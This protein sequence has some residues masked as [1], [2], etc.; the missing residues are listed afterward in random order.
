M[1]RVE[2]LSYNF[3]DGTRGLKKINLEIERGEFLGIVGRNGSGKSTLVRHL[4]GLLNPTEGKVYVK[5][6]DT[7]DPSNLLKIRQT[8]GMVFQNPYT[9]FVGTTL[10]EDV[11]FGPENLA[12]P[13]EEIR[14]RVDRALEVV[15]LENYKNHS[16]KTLSGGQ[17]QCAAI[18][19]ALAMKSE[20]IV[21]DEI[22]S[23]L[24]S[25]SREQVRE[26]LRKLRGKA[27]TIVYVT[28]RLEEV[29]YA[30]RILVMDRGQIVREGNPKT[31]FKTPELGEFGLELPPIVELLNS[32][33]AGGLALEWARLASI[34]NLAEEIWESR[35][36]I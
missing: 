5:G 7:A 2:D 1:I 28:H 24:D 17:S 14:E 8:V 18:A 33:E 25:R 30:D 26:I 21:F 22:S 13:P 23:M 11:A 12:L 32:L 34:E 3:P 4:N 10:E 31:V 29:L 27:R 20:C 19:S 36:K 6:M 15:G 35:W 9:Q 16:P